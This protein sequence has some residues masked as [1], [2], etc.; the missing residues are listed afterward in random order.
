MGKLL[1]LGNPKVHPIIE[2]LHN[3]NNPEGIYP[4]ILDFS[5]NKDNLYISEENIPSELWKYSDKYE[6]EYFKNWYKN[7][8]QN[9]INTNPKSY[10]TEM[11]PEVVYSLNMWNRYKQIY[12]IN[13]NIDKNFIY[14]ENFK[15]HFDIFDKL[16][17]DSIF[18]QYSE[19]EKQSIN[20]IGNSVATFQNIGGTLN[21]IG[22]FITFIHNINCTYNDGEIYK[23][24]IRKIV[25]YDLAQGYDNILRLGPYGLRE[26]ETDNKNIDEIVST[27]LM[28]K[29][30]KLINGNILKD[31]IEYK[32][33]ILLYLINAILYI[34][35]DD[36]TT[37][38]NNQANEVKRNM[39]KI[40]NKRITISEIGFEEK[41]LIIINDKDRNKYTNINKQNKSINESSSD[42][43]TIF[44]QKRP[45]WRRAHWHYYW[46]GEGRKELRLKFILPIL[47]NGENVDKKI[48]TI[49]RNKYLDI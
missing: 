34:C 3:I 38:L 15:L 8:I 37:D 10:V 4:G 33:H 30:H 5:L 7:N 14:D 1:K 24:N 21:I 35:S 46:C 9:K 22:T 42:E 43:I 28:P 49:V 11:Q 17:F 26:D 20:K 25:F 29:Y 40:K 39:S 19:K 47:V 44:K 41:D 13:K 12:K 18:I 23:P 32:K 31:Y 2:I 16:P 48:S 6:H 27:Y 45:H 36:I